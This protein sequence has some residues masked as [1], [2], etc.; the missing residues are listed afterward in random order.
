MLDMLADACAAGGVSFFNS[1][2]DPGW[3]NDLV[4]LTMSGMC[5]RV[6][7]VTIQEILDY[8][9]IDQPEIMFDLMGF[10]QPADQPSLLS[11]PGSTSYFWGPIVQLLADGL[12]LELDRIDDSMVRWATS[13]AYDV[14]SG[15]IEA[16]TVGALHFR[17]VGHAGGQ[18][19][20][21]IEHIT[22]MGM[23]AAP[24]WP[25][26]PSPHGGYRI[27]L[28]GM[29]TISIDIAMEHDGHHIEASSCATAMR[30]L[31]AIPAV[32][33]AAPGVLTTLDLPLVIGPAAGASWTGLSP[34]PADFNSPSPHS[35]RPS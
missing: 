8:S 29:P 4:P 11:E 24:D 27:R 30:E 18:E 20:I 28:E 2:I 35:I 12:G 33:A 23:H 21:V 1:G 10:G 17:V 13:E 25:T 22:R 3:M 34:H 5:E 9:S 16:G 26:H 15:P 19:R 6:E 32:V 7:K 31:N 14:A